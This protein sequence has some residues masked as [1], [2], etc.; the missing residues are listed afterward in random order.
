MRVV[1][2][3]PAR[4]HS[5]RLEGKPLADINGKPMVQRVYENAMKSSALDDV[6]VAT[7]DNRIREAVEKF[8][9]RA[10]L[11]SKGHPTGTDRIAE[12]AENLDVDVVVNIQGDE[13][14]VKPGMLD[15]VVSPLIEDRN[16]PMATLMHS[17]EKQD[18]D[19]P[20]VVKVVID[21]SGFALYFSRSLIPYPRYEEGHRAFEH[22]G[23]YSFQKDFLLTYSKLEPT[24]LEKSEALEQLRALENGFRI[25]VLLAKDYIPFSV[26]T[27]EDLERAREFAKKLEADKGE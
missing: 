9:G 10:V 1:A 25:K 3:I 15:E 23:I 4:Y 19:N 6:I 17:I 14:F 27:Q 8:G 2:I 7:D 24:P 16:I 13:P 12:V 21:K 20:N 5:T 22:I 11:T 26:D 18:F